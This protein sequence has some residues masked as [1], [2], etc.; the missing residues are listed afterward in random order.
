MSRA[1]RRAAFAVSLVLGGT[2]ACRQPE[3][4]TPQR[5]GSDEAAAPVQKGKAM[6]STQDVGKMLEDRGYQRLF[7]A[8]NDQAIDEAWNAAGGA[9]GL[10]AVIGDTSTSWK[11]RYLAAELRLR[12]DPAWKPA[13]PGTVARAYAEALRAEVMA[14]PWGMPGELDEPLG[15]HVVAL[16]EPAVAALGPLLTDARRI[17]YG[18]SKEATVGNEYQLRVKDFA[19]FFIAKIRNRKLTL[20]TDP[21]RRDPVIADLAASL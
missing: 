11:A 7:M 17:D 18:G 5:A 14:N 19:A 6:A 21:R 10:D 16:G 20:D 2:A 8:M 4:A 12:K 13:D 3:P 9:T 1:V 15:K